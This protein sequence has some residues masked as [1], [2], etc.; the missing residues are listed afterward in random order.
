[1]ARKERTNLEAAVDEQVGS[2]SLEADTGRAGKRR[3]VR[4]RKKKD[5]TGRERTGASATTQKSNSRLSSPGSLPQPSNDVL[6]GGLSATSDLTSGIIR[7]GRARV[8]GSSGDKRRE[9]GG[10]KEEKD[11]ELHLEGRESEES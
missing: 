3:G 1:M 2:S 11:G 6:G 5:E 4:K 7:L 9:E 8:D 10:Y